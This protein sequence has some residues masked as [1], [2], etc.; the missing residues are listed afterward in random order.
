VAARQV[1]LV[2]QKGTDDCGAAAV[3]MVLTYWGVPASAEQV[4]IAC[5][6]SGSGL[7]AGDLRDYVR[8]Q[9]L[10]SFLIRGERTDLENELSRGRPVIVGLVKPYLDGGRTH[11]EVVVALHPA[12]GTFVT[13]DPVRG[14]QVNTWEGLRAEW[15][16][17]GRPALIVFPSADQGF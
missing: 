11:Y 16:P 2:L 13:L 8:N 12:Q 5:Q 14:W 6:P 9:G 10:K 4:Q 17:A 1:P 3:A 15:E 7:R